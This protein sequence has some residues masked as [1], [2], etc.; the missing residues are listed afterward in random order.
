MK[1]MITI[2]IL[3][4]ALS[5]LG[6]CTLLFFAQDSM[7]F[8]RQPLRAESSALA[9]RLGAEEFN[10]ATQDGV[11]LHGWSR[12]ARTPGTAPWLIYFGGNA[13]EVTGMLEDLS[14]Y[15][16][17]GVV[18]ANYRGYGLSGG[19]PSERVFLADGIALYDALA[20]RPDVDRER[21]IVMGRSLGTGTAT[22]VASQRKA[23]AVV[24]LSPYDSLTAVAARI[25]PWL[26]VPLL[27]RH[28]FDS[29]S[30]APSI[31]SPMLAVAGTLDTIVPPSHSQRL[32]AAWKGEAHLHL[33]EGAD[34]NDLLQHPGFWSKVDEFI[35]RHAR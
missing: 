31:S 4:A 23:R 29:L 28:P 18:L 1:R 34:H 5:Y 26:P 12:K 30:R 3:V 21:I 32:H 25:Y 35:E 10:L 20:A 27:M 9:A 7:I 19:E 11:Q 33:L 8:L 6:I 14:R 16:G 22:Y 24:L 15:A 2:A 13:E 17:I